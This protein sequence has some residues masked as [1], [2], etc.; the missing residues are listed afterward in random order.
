[1]VLPQPVGVDVLRAVRAHLRLDLDAVRQLRKPPFGPAYAG[2]FGEALL[3][4][5]SSLDPC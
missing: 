4:S 1:V 5:W 2:T 3:R